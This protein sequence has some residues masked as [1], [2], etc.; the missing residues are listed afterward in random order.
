MTNQPPTSFLNGVDDTVV[1]RVYGHLWGKGSST[2]TRLLLIVGLVIGLQVAVQIIRRT[3]EWL[4]LKR[5]IHQKQ[6]PRL[7]RARQPKFTTISRLVV[8][9]LIFALYFF[10]FGLI[11]QEFGVNLT[12]YLAGASI[13]G[14]AISFGS[15]GLVQ[16]IVSG[17]TLIFCDAMDVGD[18]VEIASVNIIVI[19]R[20]E[21]IGLRFTTL[22]NFLHQKVMIPNRNIG[23]VSRFPPGGV[24][25]YGNVKIPSGVDPQKVVQIVGDEAKGM[26]EQFGAIILSEPMIGGVEKARG[27]GWSFFRVHFKILPGQGGL[28]EKTFRL[29]VVSAM[30][31]FD[32]DYAEWQVPVTYRALTA[33]EKLIP[34]LPLAKHGMPLKRLKDTDQLIAQRHVDDPTGV[35][36][37]S[38]RPPFAAAPL[39]I[40][41]IKI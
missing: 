21:E 30:K 6:Y 20:V 16:D 29:R 22:V 31:A 4:I 1:S 7:L 14:L 15:Q 9:T 18:L 32:P 3:S 40:R 33:E 19:G 5:K 34:V 13:I 2:E 23:T 41:K 12:A 38:S 8:S 36:A 24:D 11:L 27:S 37:S 35:L 10:A 25:A 39:P 26:W 17:M 28:I